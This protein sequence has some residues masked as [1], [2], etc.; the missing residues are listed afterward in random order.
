M[1]LDGLSENAGRRAVETPRG[2]LTLATWHLGVL[3]VRVTAW[4][5]PGFT[6]RKSTYTALSTVTQPS[7]R[8]RRETNI[9]QFT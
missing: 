6:I 5:G 7:N 4:F 8:H 1:R 9:Y 3:R 2:M